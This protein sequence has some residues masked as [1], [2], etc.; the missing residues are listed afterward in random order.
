MQIEE[1]AVD[2]ELQLESAADV[3]L[4]GRVWDALNEAAAYRQHAHRL[5]A[6][7]RTQVQPA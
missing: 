4:Y 7:A 1:D 6:R 3:A 5:I 2:G